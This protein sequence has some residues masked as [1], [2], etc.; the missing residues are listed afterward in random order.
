MFDDICKD[1]TIEKKECAG[2]EECV[3]IQNA[4]SPYLKNECFIFRTDGD[5]AEWI[6]R[7]CDE[8]DDE[9]CLHRSITKE[10]DDWI[11]KFEPVDFFRQ[12]LKRFP[13]CNPKED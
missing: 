6:S 12:L 11:V 1:C 4:L 2:M 8:I 10:G 5:T 3:F 7:M 9:I 13:E